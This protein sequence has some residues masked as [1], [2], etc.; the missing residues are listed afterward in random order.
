MNAS[1]AE[2]TKKIQSQLHTAERPQ[3]PPLLQIDGGMRR[4]DV[5]NPL[6]IAAARPK[7]YQAPYQSPYQTTSLHA[8]QGHAK[9][10]PI[11]PSNAKSGMIGSERFGF[12]VPMVP[13]QT[14]LPSPI[15]AGFHSNMGD[16]G[17]EVGGEYS[18]PQATQTF[19]CSSKQTAAIPVSA[20][21]T[22]SST[23]AVELSRLNGQEP[24]WHQSLETEALPCA[25]D[26][27]SACDVHMREAGVPLEVIQAQMLAQ[28]V[29]PLPAA[30]RPL[31]RR[32]ESLGSS[33]IAE[34]HAPTERFTLTATPSPAP[35]FTTSIVLGSG[36][37]IRNLSKTAE[38][39]DVKE[40]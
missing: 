13:S 30:L 31:G 16:T 15:S 35:G 20:L 37:E 38:M 1:A 27:Q 28:T 9:D 2:M 6:N 8:G 32:V 21:Q 11:S 34:S 17:A 36:E 23:P 12:L 4:D 24:V 10:L 19:F 3:N 18:G 7:Q 33:V 39:A 25:Q 14:H 5:P 26:L 22:P 40:A 29:A